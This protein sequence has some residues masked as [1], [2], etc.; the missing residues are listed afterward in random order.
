MHDAFCK[1]VSEFDYPDF[2]TMDIYENFE[3]I[4]D[5]IEEQIGENGLNGQTAESI[6]S[7]LLE[8]YFNES[9]YDNYRVFLGSLVV[10][11]TSSFRTEI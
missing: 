3:E 7:K 1:L 10:K 4:L 6:L 9:V 11:K 8:N 5:S 2:T